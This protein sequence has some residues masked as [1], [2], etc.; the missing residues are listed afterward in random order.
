M[1]GGGGS[2]VKKM[3]SEA[4]KA[5]RGTGKGPGVSLKK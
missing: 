4:E 3:S 5:N 2:K 1:E